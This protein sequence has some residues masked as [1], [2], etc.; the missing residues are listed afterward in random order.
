MNSTPTVSFGILGCGMIA[1]FHAK[2]IEMTEN[3]VLVGACSK[4]SA[5]AER[6]CQE[7]SVRKFDSYPDMLAC[8]DID[9]V[10]I[11]TPS[12][13]HARQV[14]QALDAGKHVV[15][16]KPMCITLG[17]CDAVIRKAEET[18]RKVCVISQHRFSDGIQEIKRA[19]DAGELGKVY[20]TQ[21]TMH[22]FRS[23]AYYDS[24]AWRGT[25]ALDGG[26]V[27]M[28]QG[29]HGVDM[30]CYLFGPAKTV[31]GFARTLGHDIEVEDTAATAIQFESGVL[32]TIDASTCCAP[33]FP[34][35]IVINCEKGRIV[36]QD[37][38]IMEWTLPT[39]CQIPV[40]QTV[41]GSG[42]GDPKAIFVTNHARQFGNFVDSILS[43]APL[44]SDAR[45]GRLPLEIILGTYQSSQ[46]EKT[47]QIQHFE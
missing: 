10:A 26:G 43:G 21:L 22:Y 33:G 25:W 5:S 24:A 38:A 27:L 6:F 7:Y 40:G 32:G 9:A 18:G 16:E 13:D 19:L 15:V 17:E 29:I 39:P 31:S 42:A 23:Q 3:A 14:L 37:N 45:A 47:V 36:T 46:E 20:S 1:N 30:L 12:G 8:P 11:C 34:Q 4:S 2:A 44:N 41:G 28:N 35:R